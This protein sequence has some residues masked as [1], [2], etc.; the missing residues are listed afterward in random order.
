MEMSSLMTSV[1]SHPVNMLSIFP[2]S[3]SPCLAAEAVGE[4][5]TGRVVAMQ[6]DVA[7]EEV[8]LAR[9]TATGELNSQKVR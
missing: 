5:Q 2:G 3:T 8:Q 4:E 9:E 7:E 6:W 1:N